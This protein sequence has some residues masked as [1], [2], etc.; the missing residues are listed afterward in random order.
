M[1]LFLFFHRLMVKRTFRYLLVWSL[2]YSLRILINCRHFFCVCVLTNSIKQFYFDNNSSWVII[3]IRRE[4][5]WRKNIIK[6]INYWFLLFSN[7]FDVSIEDNLFCTVCVCVFYMVFA[8]KTLF[9][10]LYKLNRSTI[11]TMK[12][13]W[14]WMFRTKIRV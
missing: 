3:I 7:K 11:T 13:K 5:K 9:Y 4:N 6:I 8:S 2:L 14:C 1:I 12:M 10:N